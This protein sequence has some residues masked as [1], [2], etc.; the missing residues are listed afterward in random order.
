RLSINAMSKQVL[1]TQQAQRDFLANVSHELKTPLTSIQGFAQA[2]LDGAVTTPEGLQ[3][4]AGIIY[5][6]ADRMRRLVEGLLDLARLDAGLR[7]LN[8]APL[9][10]RLVLLAVVEKFNLRA[11]EKGV[12][13]HAD[14]PPV[15]P[16]LVGDADRLAQV[17]TN[18][19][20]NALEHTPAGNSVTLAAAS[21][22]GA[23]VVNVQDTGTGIPRQ[24]LHRIFE[25]FYQVDKSRAARARS[26]GVGLGLTIT[27]E[28]VEA[29]G[30][31]L[32]VESTVGRGSTFTVRL[33]LVR[34]DDT[35]VARR[36]KA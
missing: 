27:K 10:L 18:L 11:R 24:D 36:R 7:A 15:L 33:P 31:S 6:E 17:F 23:V 35:T 20:D 5:D 1:A 26:G 16:T 8:R 13:L 29:H 28:I 25:R 12:S 34:P 21:E 14:V 22:P 3:R 4:S 30:G 19:L 9:D 32:S 2:V